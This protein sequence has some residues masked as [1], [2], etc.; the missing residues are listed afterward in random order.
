VITT[1]KF[2]YIHMHKTGGQ[3][4]NQIIEQCMPSFRHIGY[5][6]PHHLLPPE[7]SDLPI[8]GMVR[9]PWDWYISWYAFNICLNDSNPLFF[10]VSDGCQADY[11]NT[12]KNLINLGADTTRNRNYRNVLT[13]MLPNSLDGN[14]GVGLTKDCIRRFNDDDNGYY[15]WQFKRM[16]GDLDSKATY[17]GRFENLQDEFLS[18]MDQ[19]SVE[20]T[21]AIREKFKS[22]ARLNESSHSHYS[23]YY[24]DELRDLIAQKEALLIDKYGY[25]FEQVNDSGKVIEFSSVQLYGNQDSF[26]KLSGKDNNFLLLCDHIDVEPIKNKLAQIPQDAWGQSDREHRFELHRKTQSLLLI[27]DDDFR[28]YNPTYHDIYSQFEDELKPL[29]DFIAE[30]FQHNGFVVRLIFT[31]LQGHGKI[32]THADGRYSLLHCHRIHVPIISNDHVFFR[33]GGEQK[34]MRPGEMWEINNA[35]SHAVDNQSDEDRIHMIIDWVPNSTI[36]PEDKYPAP[37]QDSVS[38]NPS[39]PASELIQNGLAHHQAGRLQE[40]EAIYQSILQKHPQHADTLHLLGL[41]AHQVGKNEMA[42]DLIN[43]AIKINPNVPDFYNNCGEAYR[44]LYKNELAIARYEQ[45]LAIKPDYVEAHNNLGLALQDLGRVED[46]ITRYEQ[47]LALKPDN[48]M[49]HNNLGVALITLDRPEDAITHFE[50]ALALKPDFTEVHNNLGRALMELGRVEDAITRYKLALAIQPDYAEAHNNLGYVLMKSGQLDTAIA[51]YHKALAINPDY[52]EAHSNLAI[53]L[54]ASGR[55]SEVL[56]H[57]KR[58]LEI[59]RGNNPID[60]LHMS[61]RLIT[62]AKM[63]HDIEQFRYLESLG[64]ETD[65]FQALAEIYEAVDLE[66]DWPSDDRRA[67]P[68]SDDHRQR[69]GDT[70]NRSIHLLEA[71]EVVGSTL[72]SNLDVEKITADYFTH[73]AGMTYFDDLLSPITLASL[74][75]FLLGSTIWFDFKYAGGYLGSMLTD[76]FACPLL[77]QIADDLRRTFPDIFKNHI[78]TQSW[79]YKYDSSLSGIAV[80]ADFAA[81]NVNFWITPD[82]ANLNPASGGLVVYDVEAPLDWNFKTYNENQNRIRN[83]LSDHDSGKIVVPYGENRIVLFN[84]NLFHESDTIDFRLGYENRR[85]NITMLF[86]LRE[87]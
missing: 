75:R 72:S 43:N 4:I 52:A 65:R 79:A 42:V 68:L 38:N 76:G 54:N 26:Q 62:K 50:Q 86:G 84:S 15:S 82:T 66:I 3:S 31:K 9:N 73:S 8:V 37:K 63:N 2:V 69:I 6:Y 49:A 12:L 35:T 7:C 80:H 36:R 30:N 51:S 83:Y 39:S 25:E 57:F 40:A 45:A 70:Y 87:G 21:E 60:P 5:H 34:V 77:F 46:A 33:V 32:P 22:S 47:A 11:K 18:I 41:I 24:D 10:I 61:F 16:H 48:A 85:I 81:I 59:E 64:H 23:R 67:I 58:G 17:I 19:L 78:L 74:R 27:Y 14:Q 53:A 28:H 1:D 71:P 13:K 29:L 44:V 56:V 20:E 55:R